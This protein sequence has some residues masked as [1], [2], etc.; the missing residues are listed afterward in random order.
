VAAVRVE[1]DFASCLVVQPARLG[2]ETFAAGAYRHTQ[3]G[4]ETETVRQV[5]PCRSDLL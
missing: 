3:T 2:T 5:Q 1:Q 4:T